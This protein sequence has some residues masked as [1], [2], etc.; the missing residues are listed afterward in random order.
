MNGCCVKQ[1]EQMQ[2]IV[3]WLMAANV[4]WLFHNKEM[5][6]HMEEQRKLR[7]SKNTLQKMDKSHTE[8]DEIIKI[9]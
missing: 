7:W 2:N 8:K 3:L 4:Q 1:F 6:D 5:L 9:K